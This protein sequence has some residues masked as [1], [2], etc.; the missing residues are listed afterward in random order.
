M[1]LWIHK[2]KIQPTSTE[3]EHK[4]CYRRGFKKA[5]SLSIILTIPSKTHLFSVKSAGKKIHLDII[6]ENI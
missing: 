2:Y 1:M 6:F 3:G 4:Q 5:E